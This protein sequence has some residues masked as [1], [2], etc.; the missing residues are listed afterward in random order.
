MNEMTTA[1]VRIEE[2]DLFG[3][4]SPQREAAVDGLSSGKEFPFVI[5]GDTLACS[6]EFDL[7]AM[8]EAVERA[9]L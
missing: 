7:A 5:V 9:S 4:V 1:S 2:A 6:G 3:L 8:V